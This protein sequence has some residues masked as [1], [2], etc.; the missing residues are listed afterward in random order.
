MNKR[1]ITGGK[2][3]SHKIEEKRGNSSPMRNL[4]FRA[5]APPLN[6]KI[7]RKAASIY[8][9]RTTFS[10]SPLTYI[11]WE[12]RPGYGYYSE[13]S[14]EIQKDFLAPDFYLNFFFLCF[15]LIF[16]KRILLLILLT[17]KRQF[18]VFILLW[19]NCMCRRPCIW[20]GKLPS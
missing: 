1:Q 18:R 13:V 20:G 8:H 5:R 12:P 10:P 14:S 2:N 19:K 11:K 3:S 6:P 15:F 16:N 4:R 7:R 17:P 9:W